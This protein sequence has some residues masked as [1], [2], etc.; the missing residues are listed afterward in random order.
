MTS[1]VTPVQRYVSFRGESG[2]QW[3]PEEPMSTDRQPLRCV[4]LLVVRGGCQGSQAELVVVVSEDSSHCL[5]T[6]YFQ[7]FNLNL[8][9]LRKLFA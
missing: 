7:V 9:N 1:R 3:L 2:R 5:R 4:L 8:F 6:K